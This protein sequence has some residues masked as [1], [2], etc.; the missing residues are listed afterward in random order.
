M[1]TSLLVY[2]KKCRMAA[3]CVKSL[4]TGFTHVRTNKPPR[5]GGKKITQNQS[6]ETP[7]MSAGHVDPAPGRGGG[8]T[9]RT[10]PASPPRDLSAYAM[11]GRATFT[12]AARRPQEWSPPAQRQQQRPAPKPAPHATFTPS[13]NQR[14]L[15]SHREL[16]ATPYP[17]GPLH[18]I[19]PQAP[20]KHHHLL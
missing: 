11:D 14:L 5:R 10:A 12:R 6:R 9:R 3:C 2:I 4:K 13:S 15:V 19:S 16:T 8:P 1:V 7:S 18:T 17:L 20:V